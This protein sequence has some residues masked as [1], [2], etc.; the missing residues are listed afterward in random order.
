L[1][2]LWFHPQSPYARRVICFLDWT[3]IHS[4]RIPVALE[5]QEQRSPEYLALNP[6]GRVPF[7]VDDADLGPAGKPFALSESLAILR[8]LVEKHGFDDWYP[9]GLQMRAKSDQWLEYASQQASRPFLDLAWLRT[10]GPR[11]GMAPDEQSSKVLIEVAKKK[12]NRELPVLDARLSEYP[13]L[14]G[15]RPTLSDVAL[16]PFASLHSE[17]GVDLASEA[18]AVVAWLDRIDQMPTGHG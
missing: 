7:I 16:Y 18:P 1:L 11:L 10:F 14:A 12:L 8:Y 5:R 6:Y 2:K 17:A 3:G 9:K 15:T 13:F 4:E